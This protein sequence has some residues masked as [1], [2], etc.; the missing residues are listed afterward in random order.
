MTTDPSFHIIVDDVFMIR[1]RGT[2]VTDGPIFQSAI[3]L[4][5]EEKVL[6]DGYWFMKVAIVDSEI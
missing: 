3:A 2:V 5:V 4:K 1:G 6:H